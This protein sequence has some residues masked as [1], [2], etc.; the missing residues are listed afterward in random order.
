MLFEMLLACAEAA[1]R[2]PSSR[3]VVLVASVGDCEVAALSAPTEELWAAATGAGKPAEALGH[4]SA[5]FR[6]A[7][8]PG[9]LTRA[10]VERVR[11]A[12][13]DAGLEE[14]AV[15]AER[16]SLVVRI[17]HRP[18]AE[19][20]GELSLWLQIIGLAAGS[21]P[22]AEAY[23]VEA[24]AGPLVAARIV[25]AGRD[26]S[27]LAEGAISAAEAADRLQVCY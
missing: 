9:E 1:I 19:T 4:V 11:S 25:L 7:A 5:E 22:G 17:E 18:R 12:L 20:P 16:G 6:S 2:A 14:F 15:R 27:A 21:T 8:A 3:E 24:A 23:V 10:G 26:A 13:A